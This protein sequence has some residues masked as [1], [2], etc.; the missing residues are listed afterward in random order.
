VPLEEQDRSL[1]DTDAIDRGTA[2]LESALHRHQPGPYQL[3]AAIAALHDQAGSAEDT[4]W[5][6]IAALY[7]TLAQMTPSPVVALNQAVAVAMANGPELGLQHIDILV[8]SSQLS[9]YRHLHAA[10]ADLLRRSGHGVEATESYLR[11][12]ALTANDCERRYLQ[13]RLAEVA[14]L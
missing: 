3:Q 8:E 4:D 2:L 6:Q 9:E 12:L 10:R 14:I 13:K 1:W 5:K 7:D 11:A